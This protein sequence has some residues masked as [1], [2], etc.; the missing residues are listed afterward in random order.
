SHDRSNLIIFLRPTIVHDNDRLVALTRNKYLGLPS[1]EFRLNRH[2]ELERVEKEPLPLDVEDVF[3]GRNPPTQALQDA[4][5]KQLEARPDAKRPAQAEP[6]KP[7]TDA[8]STAP[9]EAPAP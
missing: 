4:V 3:N 1:R 6:A 8:E 9:A 7:A 2:G 5:G